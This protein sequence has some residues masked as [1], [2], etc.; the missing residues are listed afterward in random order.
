MA[1]YVDDGRRVRFWKDERCDDEL[2]TSLFTI[3]SSKEAWV[4]ESFS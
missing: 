4:K 3:A 1:F 2:F